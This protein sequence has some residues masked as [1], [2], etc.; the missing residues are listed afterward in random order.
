M[1]SVKKT[2]V[3]AKLGEKFVIESRIR[4]HVVRVDQPKT[5][6]GTDAGPTPLEYL[7]VSLAGCIGTMGRIIAHQR[8]IALRS[9][10]ITIEGDLDVDVLL[11]RT[12]EGRAGFRGIRALVK[13]DADLSSEEKRK[14]LHEIDVRCP[15]SENLQ[16]ET[17]LEIALVE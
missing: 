4:D 10:D 3:T 1:P 6:G 8:K 16:H 2:V 11:G 17:P 14:L 9:M 15:I 12:Q 5:A 7:F 13:V